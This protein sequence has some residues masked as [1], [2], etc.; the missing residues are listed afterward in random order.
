MTRRRSSEETEATRTSLV[1]AARRIVRRSGAAALTMRAVVQEAGCSVGLPYK[2]FQD[3][4][5]LVLE[6]IVSE[7]GEVSRALDAW[8]A[9]AGKATVGDNLVAF[10]RIL[11]ESDTPALLHANEIDDA[12][13][14]ERLHEVTVD[15]GIVRSF[16]EAIGQYLAREQQLG[17]IRDDVATEAF[18]FLVTG[19]VHNLVTAGELYP[20]PPRADLDRYLRQAADAIAP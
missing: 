11:L 12:A 1:A 8:V 17:R 10:A 14:V 18:G 19:A 20:R 2:V 13:F 4:A 3:R 16:D 5:A 9:N 6:L 7:L 15:S